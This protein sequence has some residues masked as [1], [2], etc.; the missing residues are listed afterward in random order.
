MDSE[1][2]HEFCWVE[3]AKHPMTYREMILKLL[4]GW[5]KRRLNS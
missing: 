4:D 2:W 3:T 5:V 1:L